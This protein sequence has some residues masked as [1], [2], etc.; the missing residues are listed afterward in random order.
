MPRITSIVAFPPLPTTSGQ[1]SGKKR[2]REEQTSHSSLTT[3]I[4]SDGYE[5]D[6][7]TVLTAPTNEGR[8]KRK[9]G[10]PPTTGQYVGLYAAKKQLEELEL[11]DSELQAEREREQKEERMSRHVSVGE[12]TQPLSEGPPPLKADHTPAEALLRRI[13]GEVEAIRRVASNSKNLKGTCVKA[14]KEASVSILE[15]AESMISRTRG[16]A[17]SNKRTISYGWSSSSSGASWVTS[18]GSRRWEGRHIHPVSQNRCP[19]LRQRRGP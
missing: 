17:S 11:Q 4:M 18:V 8:P 2:E 15:A 7:T 16:F 6:A 5:T 14:L 10:C 19:Q 12:K 13:E 9:R 1:G 3:V